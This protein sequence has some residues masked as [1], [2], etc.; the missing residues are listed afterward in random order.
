[1]ELVVCVLEVVAWTLVALVLTLAGVL[2]VED[3]EVVVVEVVV[4]ANS[5]L[6]AD[7]EEGALCAALLVASVV[8]LVL[9]GLVTESV[10]ELVAALVELVAELVVMA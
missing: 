2:N 1:M 9:D 6:V 7:V 10:E 5:V 4:V 3:V 8:E